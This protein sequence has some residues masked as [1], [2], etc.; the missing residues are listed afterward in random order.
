MAVGK[1]QY[2]SFCAQS[3]DQ[4]ERLVAGPTVHIC[5][6]CVDLIHEIIHSAPASADTPDTSLERH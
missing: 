3:Q 1:I 2:C 5:N 6:E 4:V